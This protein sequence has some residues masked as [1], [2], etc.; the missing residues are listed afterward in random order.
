MCILEVRVLRD[1]LFI[2]S[3]IYIHNLTDLIPKKS[4]K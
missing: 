3:E 2:R 4:I 1:Y